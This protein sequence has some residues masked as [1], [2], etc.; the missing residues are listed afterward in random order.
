MKKYNMPLAEI[1]TVD[2][3]DIMVT[4]QGSQLPQDSKDPFKYSPWGMDDLI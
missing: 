4:S 1:V 2:T 3:K